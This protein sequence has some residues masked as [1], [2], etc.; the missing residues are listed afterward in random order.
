MTGALDSQISRHG[1][2]R[3]MMTMVMT[4][5]RDARETRLCSGFSHDCM[6]R[7]ARKKRPAL[8][9]SKQGRLGFP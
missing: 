4:R 6:S 5:A 3:V 8:A 2:G 7:L 9:T 1:D